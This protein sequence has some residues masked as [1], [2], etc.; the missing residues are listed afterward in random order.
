MPI[1]I[2]WS[3]PWIQTEN[4]Y[5]IIR[6]GL[7]GLWSGNKKIRRKIYYC[8]GSEL[9][10][11]EVWLKDIQSQKKQPVATELQKAY[12]AESSRDKRK[13]KMLLRGAVVAA[14][15]IMTVATIA[16]AVGT[17]EA[18][19]QTEIAKLEEIAGRV[20]TLLDAD[21][22]EA[23]IL[24]IKATGESESA[25]SEVREKTFAQVQSSLRDAAG[26]ARERNLL[27]A[28]ASGVNSLALSPDGKILAS[29]GKDGTIRLWNTSG[30]PIRQHDRPLLKVG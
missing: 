7:S 27:T 25:S 18:Q 19:K 6:N 22:L 4:T 21:P 14:F 17:R 2:N 26:D 15:S 23:L 9:A 28:N 10:I 12:I 5:R 29:A 1:L 20:Q 24:A 8:A 30:Y 13:N 11:A 3:E 16:T